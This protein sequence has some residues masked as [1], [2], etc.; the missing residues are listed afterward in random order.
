MKS[1][2]KFQ[3]YLL[4]QLYNFGETVS[5]VFWTDNW[6]PDSFYDKIDANLS[7]GLHTL[8]LLDIKVKEQTVENMM[9]FVGKINLPVIL[10]E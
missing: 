1:I 9:R 4:F 5:I 2:T 10:F 3:E 6:Q 8:C 7:R